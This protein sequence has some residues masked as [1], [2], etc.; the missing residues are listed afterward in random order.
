MAAL[1]RPVGLALLGGL[2]LWIPA[3]GAE[4][5]LHGLIRETSDYLHRGYSR[6]GNDPSVQLN[7]DFSRD[8]GLYAG[9]WLSEVDFGGA[10]VEGIAYLGLRRP[11]LDGWWVDLSFS[12]Y[13]YDTD[14]FGR[15]GD[16][17][18][19]YASLNLRDRGSL[20]FGFSPDPYGLGHPV[21]HVQAEA[22]HPLTDAL[23]V[24]AGAGF[25]RAVSAYHYDN[26]YWDA[27]LTWFPGRCF[28]V[29]LRYHGARQVNAR[30]H[31][32]QPGGDL[33]DAAFR[34]RVVLSVSCGR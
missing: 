11:V 32:D 5:G 13:A 34:D 7:V 33:G 18:A 25:E 2:S 4:P 30:P 27:G 17:A 16:Y 21:G 6:S 31:D 8:D 22:R 12:Q 1:S 14:V 20:G 24:S 3:A 9:G 15:A 26:V 19:L 23:E 10:D 28:A 29:D